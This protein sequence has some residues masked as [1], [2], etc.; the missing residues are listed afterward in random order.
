MKIAIVD[1][2]L[3][4]IDSLVLYLE[5]YFPDAEVVYRTTDPTDALMRLP[6]IKPH[7]LFLDVEMPEM[8]G[9]ELLEQLTDQPFDIIFTTA[10]S[11]Y[12]VQAFKAKAVD[13][14]LKPLDPEELKKAIAD[15]R[16]LHSDRLR[17]SS[18]KIDELLNYLKQ[19]GILKSKIAIPVSDGIEF[20]RVEDIMYCKSQSNYTT[21]FF[22]DGSKSVVSKTI[23]EIE[24]TLV[25]YSFQR[26][27]RSYLIN[28]AY[29]KKY[30][31]GDGGYLVMEDDQTIPVSKQH[32][33][34]VTNLFDSINR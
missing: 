1:D 24:K 12:A 4:C 9:F 7:L 26:V 14:L 21:I 29:M 32:K 20:V 17:A 28:P 6:E 18:K 33:A 10:Y 22:S 8:N 16:N 23:K 27:H 25:P 19:E 2:E 11:K 30:H 34:L 3:H 15:W 31:R 13:Y 5:K